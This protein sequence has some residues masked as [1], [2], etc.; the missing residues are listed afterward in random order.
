MTGRP[1]PRL[2]VPLLSIIMLVIMAGEAMLTAA[3][4]QMTNEFDVP[5]VFESWILPVVLLVGAS[6]A[7]FIGTAGDQWGR[8]RLLLLCMVVYLAGLICGYLAQDILVLLLSRAMQ[9]IGIASFPLAYA[10]VRDQL[11]HTEADVGIGVL[12]AM[13][14]GGMFLGVIIGSFLIEIFSW[15]MTYLALIPCTVTLIL[16][17]LLGIHD[18][19]REP[20]PVGAARPDWFGFLTL[21]SF[22]ILGL[23]ALSLGESGE[24]GLMIRAGFGIGALIAGILFVRNELRVAHPL[25]DLH[26]AARK[27]VL[28][29]ILVGTLTIFSF[30]VL[31]QEMPFLIQAET[32]LGLTAAAV[33]LILVPGTLCDMAAGPITGRLVASY[34]VRIPCVIG[35]LLLILSMVILLSAGLSF[36]SLVIGWMIFS[37]GMSTASTAC[38]IAMIEFVPATRTAEATGL[39]QCVQTIGGMVGPVVTGIVIA[40]SSVTSVRDGAQWT[41]PLPSAFMQLHLLVLCIGVVIL[42]CSLSM[43]PASLP[44]TSGMLP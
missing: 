23:V 29:M 17:T 20:G 19:R 3:L 15:R 33:G 26:L 31:L 9:G 30:L 14:G 8:R 10:L 2:L 39:M 5:G 4:P 34:G 13:Y 27:P 12:S 25:I 18:T 6:A 43:K 37:A 38:I 24:S 42:V 36:L 11:P 21:L 44:D 41:I 16:L 32:G 1:H 35:S 7:P 40:A 28:L 22:L